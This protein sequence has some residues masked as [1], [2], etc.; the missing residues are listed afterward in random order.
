MVKHPIA[1][2]LLGLIASQSFAAD[3]TFLQSTRDSLNRVAEI[4]YPFDPAFQ[5]SSKS[6]F[7]PLD[8]VLIHHNLSPFDSTYV[9]KFPSNVSAVYHI[10]PGREVLVY[11]VV[12]NTTVPYPVYY[13]NVE[14]D[15]R[16]KEYD[17]LARESL[18]NEK[19]WRKATD[20]LR[21]KYNK[22]E[23]SDFLYSSAIDSVSTEYYSTEHKLK[24]K[25]HVST[26]GYVGAPELVGKILADTAAVLKEREVFVQKHLERILAV[27]ELVATMDS[28]CTLQPGRKYVLP[29]NYLEV[30]N[31]EPIGSDGSLFIPKEE[32][33]IGMV[34]TILN[35]SGYNRPCEYRAIIEHPDGSIVGTGFIRDYGHY[36]SYPHVKKYATQRSLAWAMAVSVVKSELSQLVRH[37]AVFPRFQRTAVDSLDDFVF[38]IDSY[39]D[40][41]DAFGIDKRTTFQLTL[42]Y[43][44]GDDS[45]FHN[46]RLVDSKIWQK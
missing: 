44:G 9:V 25:Y 26:R 18:K 13:V 14:G 23:I 30:Y 46:W 28:L 6:K 36:V 27:Q 31:Y 10:T 11:L 8:T 45:Y 37:S 40:A 41:R 24:D 38:V 39:F 12:K 22:R 15:T 3:P 21:K 19:Q 4:M 17:E 2:L 43:L 20:D 32:F 5:L 1:I 34:I 33:A 35:R 16:G 42:Q 29:D 7:I